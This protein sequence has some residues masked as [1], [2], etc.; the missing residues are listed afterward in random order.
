MLM[1]TSDHN[2]LLIQLGKTFSMIGKEI[3]H[4][5]GDDLTCLTPALDQVLIITATQ[6]AVNVKQIAALLMITSGAA[7]Q[8]IAALEK[9]GAVT[10]VTNEQDRREVI[11]QL[12]EKGNGLYAQIKQ[13]RISLLQEIF[14]GLDDAELRTLIALITKATKK[15]Q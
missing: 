6:E 15:Y 3:H 8:H 7:T 13:N 4:Q 12:T 2:E 14:T 1:V 9:I 5:H 10:R 11:V